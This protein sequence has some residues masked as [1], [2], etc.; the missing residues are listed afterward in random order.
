L[1]LRS[2][3]QALDLLQTAQVE[4][5]VIDDAALALTAYDRPALRP[6]DR[7]T[8]LIRPE[9]HHKAYK[10]LQGGGW[11]ASKWIPSRRR[12]YTESLSF[13]DAN[14]V[15]LIMRWFAV[16]RRCAPG[17]DND[18][19]SRIIAHTDAQGNPIPVIAPADQLVLSASR[20]PTAWSSPCPSLRVADA[21]TLIQKQPLDWSQVVAS[22]I[23][24]RLTLQL[25]HLLAL[26]ALPDPSDPA[27]ADVMR[28]LSATPTSWMLRAE[29]G[30]L[31]RRATLPGWESHLIRWWLASDG[32][33]HVSQGARYFWRWFNLPV[34]PIPRLR[35][36][37]A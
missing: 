19:W 1:A 18:L 26:I 20:L 14:Q 35:K 12:P 27:L 15:L 11:K 21:L 3:T 6:L 10:A 4:V 33:R 2:L 31:Q 9:Q 24:Y 13:T 36:Q 25:Y 8:V 28:S 16:D 5:M 29:N 23:H 32:L 7:L 37:S 34:P 30:A 17:I 22:A